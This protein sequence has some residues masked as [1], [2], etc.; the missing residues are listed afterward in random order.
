MLLQLTWEM[1]I[2]YYYNQ[3]YATPTLLTVTLIRPFLKMNPLAMY[4]YSNLDK[5]LVVD[6]SLPLSR[7]D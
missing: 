1:L 5:T 2:H 7:Y 4:S 3:R 6:Q